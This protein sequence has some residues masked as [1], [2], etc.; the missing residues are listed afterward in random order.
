M[1]IIIGIV[2]SDSDDL[3]ASIEKMISHAVYREQL[4]R[5]M[6]PLMYLICS[7]WLLLAMAESPNNERFGAIM[8]A[9]KWQQPNWQHNLELISS[10]F[11]YGL[12]GNRILESAKVQWAGGGE[13]GDISQM[14]KDTICK[15]L[16]L[17]P[18]W[19]KSKEALEQRLSVLLEMHPFPGRCRQCSK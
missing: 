9:L 17:W 14:I 6:E 11:G 13:Y 1:P 4:A 18:Q 16:E 15:A 8:S 12:N 7:E 3:D 10:E 2:I 19:K 5:I